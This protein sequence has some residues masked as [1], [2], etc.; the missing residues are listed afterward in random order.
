[1]SDKELTQLFGR[2]GGKSRIRKTL[3]RYFPSDIKTYVEPFIGAGSVMLGYKFKPETKVVINDKDKELMRTWRILKKRPQGDINKYDTTS[4]SELTRLMN[5]KG[6]S[7]M[8]KLVSFMI[9]FRN[10]FGNM[11]TGKVYQGTNPV[12]KLKQLDDFKE[13]LKNVT[14]LNQGYEGVIT[15]YDNPNTFFYFDP[16]YESSEDLY[17]HGGF[18]FVKFADRLKKIKGK[19]MLSLNDSKN[20]RELFKGFKIRGLTVAPV[21]SD[22]IGDKPRKEVIITNY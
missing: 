9:K 19:F 21:G 5:V 7:E 10:T 4:L 3:Y 1:M 22:G 2:V 14:I 17:K 16:P 13:K 11:G 12:N 15:K 6:G 18:D 8:D 20:V